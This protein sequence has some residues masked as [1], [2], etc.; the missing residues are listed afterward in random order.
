VDTL[1]HRIHNDIRLYWD[2]I[3]DYNLLRKKAM[4]AMKYFSTFSGIGGFELGI[5]QAYDSI[6]KDTKSE[7]KP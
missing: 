7:G 2:R 3:G 5:Q 4:G 1:R 6:L